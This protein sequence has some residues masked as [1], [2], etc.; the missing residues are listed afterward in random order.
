MLNHFF[1]LL[2][3][4]NIEK[5]C[6]LRICIN[7]KGNIR[8]V[9]SIDFSIWNGHSQNKFCPFDLSH[10]KESFDTKI[11]NILSLSNKKSYIYHFY[12]ILSLNCWIVS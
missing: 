3:E 5:L 9:F 7:L 2:I 12:N 10:Y 6:S 8:F 11:Y 4:L 1:Y